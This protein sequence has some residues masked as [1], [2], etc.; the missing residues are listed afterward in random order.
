MAP[1]PPP[2]RFRIGYATSGFANHRLEDAIDV[3][4]A[5]GYRAIT[6]TLDVHH[7][8][9]FAPD[10]RGRTAAVRKRVEAFGLGVVVECGARF[11]LDPRN[12]HRPGLL[13]P[14][15]KRREDFLRTAIAV[16][17]DLGADCV[18]FWS[19]P[20][21]AGL[22]AAEAFVKLRDATARLVEDASR[23]GV[24]LAFEP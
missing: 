22:G 16:A 2:S 1:L 19:G 18:S 7:L 12:K 4:A 20:R 17:A 23:A 6:L 13:D 15:G 10:L 24:D 3:L 14:D 8:D 11:L 9:P 5:L 21:P